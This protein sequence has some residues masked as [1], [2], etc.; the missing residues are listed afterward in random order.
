MTGS[1]SSVIKLKPEKAFPVKV[2]DLS[3]DVS[4]KFIPYETSIDMGSTFSCFKDNNG[5]EVI[6]VAALD[7]KY[8]ID[9]FY[10]RHLLVSVVIDKNEKYHRS[11]KGY[12]RTEVEFELETASCVIEERY[13][14]IL[15]SIYYTSFRKINNPDK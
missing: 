12:V 3:G 8:A 4:H 7:Y 14:L 1:C 13:G 10:K 9:Y 2:I 15:H 6:T 11:I 5:N